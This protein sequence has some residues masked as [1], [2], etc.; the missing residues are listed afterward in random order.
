MVRAV[1]IRMK[2]TPAPS[3]PSMPEVAASPKPV[4]ETTKP[5]RPIRM[6]FLRPILSDQ[7]AQNGEVNVHIRAEMAKAPATRVSARWNSRP[8]AGSTDCSPMFP[9]VAI[10]LTAN[11]IMKAGERGDMKSCLDPCSEEGAATLKIE[12]TESTESTSKAGGGTAVRKV[13]KVSH[14]FQRRLK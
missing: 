4:I 1:A 8:I 9:A 13:G 5:V 7:R 14:G 6:T 12:S 11:R 3:Q 2:A 10:R